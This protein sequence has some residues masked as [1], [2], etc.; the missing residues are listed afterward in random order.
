MRRVKAREYACMLAPAMPLQ[1]LVRSDPDLAERPLAILDQ[2]GPRATV[3][4]V[5]RRAYEAGVR[6]KMTASEARSVA[7]GIVQ[8]TVPAPVLDA[9]CQALLD[10]ALACSPVVE[11][12]APGSVILDITG[13]VRAYKS[14]EALGCSLEAFA[15]RSGLRVRVAIAHGPRLA[16]LVARAIPGVTVIPHGHE[17]A[18]LAPLPIEAMTSSAHLL[19]VLR[20]LGVR[21]IGE[22]AT[23]EPSGVGVRLGL[24]AFELHR[25]ARGEDGAIITPIQA[26]ENFE[27]AVALD[28]VIEHADPLLF[29]VAAALERLTARLEARAMAPASLHLAL[30]LDP[31]GVHAISLTLPEPSSDI[32]SMVALVRLSLER[33][34]PPRPVT[35]FRLKAIMGPRTPVQGHLFGPVVPAPTG[36]STLLTRLAA[37]AGPD[38]VGAPVVKDSNATDPV[39]MAP[40][41]PP[42][43]AEERPCEGGRMVLGFRRFRPPVPVQVAFQGGKPTHVS[44]AGGTG[45]VYGRV[46]RAAG[47]WYCETGWWTGEAQ[48]GASWDVEVGDGH[49]VRLWNDLVKGAWYIEGIYD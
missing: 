11:V 22:F 4:H 33:R 48:A 44:P 9:A 3:T 25:L 39:G 2:E 45:G 13:T 7:P 37:L 15:A 19:D 41:R 30:D 42:A 5:S 31:D 24:E 27:E 38:C 1:A 28:H 26:Q 8:R 12:L 21:T 32:R 36:L 43:L 18:T 34:P 47:P 35:G 29:L 17:A 10:V 16:T 49:L 40:F 23:M 6:P 14:R 20:R 46:R